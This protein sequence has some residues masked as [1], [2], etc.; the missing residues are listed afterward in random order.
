MQDSV[1]KAKVRQDATF[2]T[3]ADTLAFKPPIEH[4]YRYMRDS[5]WV[6]PLRTS[7]L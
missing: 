5:S 7:E 6:V 3:T 1:R 2:A 4:L